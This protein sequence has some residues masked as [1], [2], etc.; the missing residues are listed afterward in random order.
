[1]IEY[2]ILHH[3]QGNA[4]FRFIGFYFQHVQ[5]VLWIVVI[6]QSSRVAIIHYF[7]VLFN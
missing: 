4:R 7:N 3:H 2:V 1:M 5:K 6:R